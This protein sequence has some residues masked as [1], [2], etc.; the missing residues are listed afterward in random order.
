MKQFLWS[1]KHLKQ[2]GISQIQHIS[3][4]ASLTLYYAIDYFQ[5][6]TVASVKITNRIVL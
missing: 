1:F 4:Y 2:F 3:E 5:I 6:L